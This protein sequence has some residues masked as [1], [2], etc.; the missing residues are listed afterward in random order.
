MTVSKTMTAPVPATKIRNVKPFGYGL[1][2][3]EIVERMDPH[4]AQGRA[5]TAGL[6]LE[7]VLFENGKMRENNLLTDPAHDNNTVLPQWKVPA[8]AAEASLKRTGTTNFPQTTL[9][10]A[11]QMVKESPA[12]ANAVIATAKKLGAEN[13]FHQQA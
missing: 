3:S 5:H 7:T 1:P 8:E 11:Q 10:V 2:T 9:E 12:F 4:S 6:L 13:S